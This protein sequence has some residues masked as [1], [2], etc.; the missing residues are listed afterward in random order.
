ML[1]AM[2][3]VVAMLVLVGCPTPPV[4]PPPPPT[5]ALQLVIPTA[6]TAQLGRPFSYQLV[7]H[8]GTLPYRWQ[9][10]GA[11]KGLSVN[12]SGG[13]YGTPN[14]TAGTFA[15]TVQ[16]TDSGGQIAAHYFTVSVDDS[17]SSE[18]SRTAERIPDRHD[19]DHTRDH[20]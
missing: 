16:V 20:S 7:A 10:V 9:L 8:G 3:V 11:P 19:K 1:R 5:V 2:V 4:P 12:A 6:L 18:P 15:F 17:G 13:L 14:G